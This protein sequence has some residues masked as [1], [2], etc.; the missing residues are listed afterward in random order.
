MP[1]ADAP[2]PSR[3]DP[4]TPACSICGGLLPA[5]RLRITCSDA[6]RQA[7]WRRRHQ[8]PVSPPALPP[9]QPRKPHT[10]YQCPN[11]DTRLLGEQRCDCGTF[12]RRLGPGGLSPCCGEPVT[13]EEL[14]EA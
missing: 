3:N 11:C 13:F 1:L 2:I 6:C 9:A 14:L 8:P 4:V 7:A 5:G 10:V 12:M